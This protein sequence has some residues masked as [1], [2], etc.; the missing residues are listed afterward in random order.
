MSIQSLNGYAGSQPQPAAAAGN[1]PAPAAAVASAPRETPVQQTA[2]TDPQQVQQAVEQIKTA[3]PAK[4]SALQFSLDDQ[5][6][7]TV[8]KVIDSET[9][10][11]IRQIP[12]EELLEIARALDKMQGLLLKQS[13]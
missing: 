2:P 8:V 10:D 12:S 7:K 9:G 3:L 5:T 13:A 6:G 4:A 1:S 11:L